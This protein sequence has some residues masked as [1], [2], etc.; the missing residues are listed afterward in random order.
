MNNESQ[1]IHLFFNR[2]FI[3]NLLKANLEMLMI[4]NTYKTN[5]FKMSLLII[6]EQINLN[7]T[8]YVNFCFM[9]KKTI[10]FYIWVMT[11]LKILYAHLKLSFSLTTIINMKRIL[12]SAIKTIFFSINHMLCLWHINKNVLV[13]CKRKFDID[14]TW[15]IFYVEWRQLIYVEIEKNFNRL[16]I[17][18]AIK[19]QSHFKMIEYLT[20][21]Y[22]SIQ[23]RFVKCFTNQ[24]KHFLIIITSR[25]KNNHVAL[26]KQLETFK[27]NLKTIIDNTKLLL[28][29]EMNNYLIVFNLTKDR[30][31]I[32]FRKT[33]F[34]RIAEQITLFAL[35]KILNQ[36]NL[37]TRQFTAIKACTRS[38]AMIIDLF[39]NHKIQKQFYDNDNNNDD[40]RSD[41]VLFLNNIHFHWRRIFIKFKLHFY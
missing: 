39:C 28:I 15:K 17:D 30:Y 26:K 41:D 16:W 38:F 21:I 19:Y 23:K 25:N 18:F 3:Q 35:R 31:S 11:R 24:M 27:N 22:Y 34:R 40:D 5:R 9:L 14:E 6:D 10:E 20:F 36:Y 33:I 8:F 12:I 37:L 1:I 4:N 7:I 13:K 2:C 32:D 29:N